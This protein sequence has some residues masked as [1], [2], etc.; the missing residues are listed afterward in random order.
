[1]S[2]PNPS[3][4]LPRQPFLNKLKTALN[5]GTGTIAHQELWVTLAHV[6]LRSRY[7][8]SLLGP[9]WLTI[10]TGILVV[11]IGLLYGGLL[12]QPLESYLPYIAIGIVIWS[13]ISTTL[14]EATTLF[15]G[16][17]IILKQLP[18]PA[19][20]FVT[21]LLYRNI[22]IFA[23]NMIIVVIVVLIYPQK[24]S[25]ALFFIPVGFLVLLVNLWWISMIISIIGTRYRDIPPIIQ[26]VLQI[27]FFLTPVL[28]RAE[29]LPNR[30]IFVV[31]NP[32]YHLIEI[33]RAPI[34]PGIVPWTSFSL[35]LLSGAAGS[36]LALYALRWSRT[37]LIYWL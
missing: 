9:L 22:L 37:R 33:V 24:L 28:W 19:S 27:L 18:V 2:V 4:D 11:G 36:A 3:D 20:L 25:L 31:S 1:M 21:R 13:L 7:R 23:H 26:S 6:D 34:I 15:P 8:G 5:L 35:C 32:F 10:A 29:D 30:A 16:E 14:S 12:G 17:G